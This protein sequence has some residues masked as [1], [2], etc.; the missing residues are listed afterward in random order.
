MKQQDDIAKYIDHTVL[1]ATATRDKIEQICKEA[2]QYKFASVCVNSC[3][4]ALCAK[5]L[6]KSEV[7]VCTVVGFPL[8]AMSSES[9]AYEA[10]K[11]VLAGAD[12]VDMVI[13]IGYLKNHDDDLVQDD[14]A[15]VKAACG[16]ATL[17]VIIETCLLTDEEKVRACRLAKASGA[18][19]VKTSTGFSTGGATVE[20][21]K[22]MRKTVGPELG[23]KASGGIR[24]YADARAM[25]DAGAT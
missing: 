10:K 4:V 22:L 12:E 11:A 20:D 8:G 18:D 14:I 24:T 19:F 1:A 6:E 15:M 23:V 17:K 7:K 2:D 21:I 3:W 13:N 9:K 5:L 16:N 25:I